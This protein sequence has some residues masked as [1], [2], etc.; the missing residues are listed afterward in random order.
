MPTDPF[1]GEIHL[2]GFDFAP[3]DW[4]FCN[5]AAYDIG[6]NQALYSLIFTLYGD[7]SEDWRNPI[8]LLPNLTSRAPVGIDAVEDK[9]HNWTITTPV[10]R[11]A[12]SE[13]IVLT[14][15]TMPLHGHSASFSGEP[16]EGAAIRASQN[17]ATLS[18]PSEGAYLAVPRPNTFIQTAT[19]GYKDWP[20]GDDS[21]VDVGG[22]SGG[23]SSFAGGVELETAGSGVPIDIRNP[24]LAMSYCIALVGDYPSRG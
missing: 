21:L 12:G 23:V 4:A 14:E 24:F 15:E 22:V 17:L 10:G 20:N 5:G 19:Y 13:Q 11:V 16:A 8:P 7:R 6:Q 3:R 18:E 9:D 1:C 2:F